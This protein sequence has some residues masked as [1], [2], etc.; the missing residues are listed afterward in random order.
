MVTIY[1]IA[2][3][4]DWAQRTATYAPAEW[5]DEGFIHC[6][7]AEQLVR[8]ANR[9]FAGRDDLVVLAIETARLTPLV[10]WEDTAGTGE[11]YPH[12]Y[13]EVDVGAVVAA[14]PLRSRSDGTFAWSP[15]A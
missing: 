13:G 8:T 1:H 11:D 2:S 15:D 7:T 10:V 12:I 5:R 6:S 14:T 9:H 3:E 4:A